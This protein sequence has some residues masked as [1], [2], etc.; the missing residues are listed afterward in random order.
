MRGRFRGALVHGAGR[1]YAAVGGGSSA[2]N[3]DELQNTFFPQARFGIFDPFNPTEL[4]A[5]TGKSV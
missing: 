4:G 3:V 2:V 5:G 1:S